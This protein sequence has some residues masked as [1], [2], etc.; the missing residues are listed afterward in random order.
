M[1]QF[2][3][4]RCPLAPGSQA[5]QREP[6][7]PGPRAQA[8]GE[9]AGCARAPGWAP[10]PTTGKSEGGIP[11]PVGTGAAP[12]GIRA[13][14]HSGHWLRNLGKTLPDVGRGQ[15]S[16]LG[17]GPLPRVGPSASL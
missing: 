14:S 9:D 10:N 7:V 6:A 5:P 15:G 11:R 2:P 8:R 4:L 1:C 13:L 3:L 17:E 12:N 16:R